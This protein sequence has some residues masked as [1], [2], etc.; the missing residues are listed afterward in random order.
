LKPRQGVASASSAE[1]AKACQGAGWIVKD[2]DKVIA[3][4]ESARVSLP[5]DSKISNRSTLLQ[6]RLRENL[7]IFRQRVARSKNNLPPRHRTLRSSSAK[8]QR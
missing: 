2:R 8:Q 3:E 4:L 5:R 1:A 6:S 7:P